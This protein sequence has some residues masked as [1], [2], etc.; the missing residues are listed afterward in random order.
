MGEGKNTWSIEK[1]GKRGLLMGAKG[2]TVWWEKILSQGEIL[3]W[4]WGGVR[5]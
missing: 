5:N 4:R 1:R 2:D 3:F